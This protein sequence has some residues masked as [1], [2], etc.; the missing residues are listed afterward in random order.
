M[1]TT[2]RIASG[3]GIATRGSK[4]LVKTSMFSSRTNTWQQRAW[5]TLMLLP[6]KEM[7]MKI[8]TR[9]K[10]T[11]HEFGRREVA[12]LWMQTS[13]QQKILLSSTRHWR[14]RG[15]VDG[16]PWPTQNG[17]LVLDINMDNMSIQL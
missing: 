1:W 9:N 15:W 2:K 3:M 12:N 8:R 4:T 14:P 11:Q 7:W 5:H 17:F 16:T 13:Q 10:Q 6:T